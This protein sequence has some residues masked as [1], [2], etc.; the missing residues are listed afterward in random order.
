METEGE[1]PGGLGDGVDVE[2]VVGLDAAVLRAPGDV[3]AAGGRDRGHEI[4]DALLG[5]EVGDRA[6]AMSGAAEARLTRRGP[7]RPLLVDLSGA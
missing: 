7:G 2:R 3:A 5:A 1:R 6:E 4:G